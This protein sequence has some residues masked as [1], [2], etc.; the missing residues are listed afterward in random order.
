MN[1]RAGQEEIVVRRR[2]AATPRRTATS[3]SADSITELRAIRRSSV[4]RAGRLSPHIL[5]LF[6]CFIKSAG[7]A[8]VEEEPNFDPPV[9]GQ[10]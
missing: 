10:S 9:F 8:L 7:N 4:A 3:N 6:F 1:A 2:A 5:Y